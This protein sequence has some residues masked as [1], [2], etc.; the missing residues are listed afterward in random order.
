[1]RITKGL[2]RKGKNIYWAIIYYIISN[3]IKNYFSLGA[4]NVLLP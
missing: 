2:E 3:K 4:R 1:M